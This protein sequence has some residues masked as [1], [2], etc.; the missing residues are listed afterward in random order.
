MK[1]K[2]ISSTLDLGDHV[3]NLLDSLYLFTKE[4]SLKIVTEMSISLT[5]ASLVQVQQALVDLK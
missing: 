1:T 4:L 2:S 5:I 3:S